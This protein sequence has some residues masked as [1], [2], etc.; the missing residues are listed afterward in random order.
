MAVDLLCCVVD[1]VASQR[2]SPLG[3]IYFISELLETLFFRGRR[4]ICQAVVGLTHLIY[5]VLNVAI[6]YFRFKSAWSVK[7][8]T[9]PTA[10]GEL[11]STNIRQLLASLI[12]QQWV[13]FYRLLYQ[14]VV[15]L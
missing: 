3:L 10:L 5:R 9:F 8:R 11:V 6:C 14:W 12:A 13:L 1:V 2:V 7:L 15:D 4:L